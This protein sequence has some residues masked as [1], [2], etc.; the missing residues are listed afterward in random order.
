MICVG[1]VFLLPLLRWPARKFTSVHLFDMEE[2]PNMLYA[3]FMI[4]GSSLVYFHRWPVS[5]PEV[6][7]G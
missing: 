7:G 6:L 2:Y 5:D 1:L 3:V 4:K